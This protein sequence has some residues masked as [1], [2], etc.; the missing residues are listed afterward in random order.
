MYTVTVV[1]S[2]I[3]A[4]IPSLLAAVLQGALHALALAHVLCL[5][6]TTVFASAALPLH[7]HLRPMGSM[8]AGLFIPATHISL[9]SLP[10]TAGAG[11]G[12]SAHG[13]SLAGSIA[14][15]PT[16]KATRQQT[17]G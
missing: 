12:A 4:L 1:L 7:A 5:P 6:V 11:A 13:V 3:V 16:G 2:C 17:T 15:L 14:I 8:P 9:Q 10:A